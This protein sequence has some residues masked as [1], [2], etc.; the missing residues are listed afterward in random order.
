MQPFW[1]F[2]STKWNS[3]EQILRK[4]VIPS[5]DATDVKTGSMKTQEKVALL[6]PVEYMPFAYRI[7]F[8]LDGTELP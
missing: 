1:G 4:Q 6:V 3:S 8:P 7:H 5:S 2:R